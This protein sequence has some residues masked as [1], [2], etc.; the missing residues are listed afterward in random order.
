MADLMSDL[1]TAD[2]LARMRP[3]GKARKT[4]RQI[5]DLMYVADPTETDAAALREQNWT[6]PTIG[7]ADIQ[8]GVAEATGVP[9][10][11]RAGRNMIDD[12]SLANATDLGTR[13]AMMAM[14]PAAALK[15]LGAGYAAAGGRD[16]MG[17]FVG[18]A[19]AQGKRGEATPAVPGLAPEQAAE[20]ATAKRKVQTGSFSNGA[21]RRATES[22]IQRLEALSA[23][24]VR[25]NN[26]A[27]IEA[28]KERKASAQRDYDR[29]VDRADLMRSEILAKDRSFKDSEVGKVYDK[30]GGYLPVMAGVAG[31]AVGRL[32]HGGGGGLAKSLGIPAAEG[33][34]LTFAALNAPLMYDAF[35]TPPMNPKRE[36]T[37]AYA[38]ELPDAHPKKAVMAR[39]AETL[40]ELN[41]VRESAR[42]ALFSPG[43][44]MQRLMTGVLEGAPAGMLGANLGPASRRI[45]EGVGEIPGA[46]ATGYGRGMA[47]A[48]EARGVAADARSAAAAAQSDALQAEQ[49]LAE[50]AR[51]TGAPTG[52]LMSGAP[53]QPTRPAPQPAPSQSPSPPASAVPAVVRG[54]SAGVPATRQDLMSEGFKPN[55]SYGDASSPKVQEYLVDAASRGDQVAGITAAHLARELGLKPT[56]A[57]DAMFNLKRA[58]AATGANINDP[59]QLRML[60]EAMNKRAPN[61]TGTG[62][63]LTSLAGPAIA[64]PAAAGLGLLDER[65]F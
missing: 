65:R 13:A 25:Q 14:R 7:P 20:L 29:A 51:R 45:I 19:E 34:G 22:T 1:T 6:P 52:D 3:E 56:P 10:T 62:S 59:V 27:A 55:N 31:G 36:A 21:D 58:A 32:A 5:R 46:L 9:G 42:A 16:L 8:R 30:T 49:A 54:E 37:E 43:G 64:V 11:L 23:D 44:Q 57:K 15:I 18:S 24:Y 47:R 26:Q 40:P 2:V 50:A 53:A 12:P 28:E 60:L 63:I 38:R 48:S 4:A 33:A 35:S 41:P 39:Y 17:P 61:S